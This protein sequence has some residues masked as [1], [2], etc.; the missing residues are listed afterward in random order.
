MNE[1]LGCLPSLLFLMGE[2]Q[3]QSSVK[4]YFFNCFSVYKSLYVLT[5]IT[6]KQ[7]SSEQKR[8]ASY[9]IYQSITGSKCISFTAFILYSYSIRFRVTARSKFYCRNGRN[10]F[11]GLIVFHVCSSSFAQTN[12]N[13][14]ILMRIG[15]NKNQFVSITASSNNGSCIMY[16]VKNE[17]MN[18]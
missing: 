6:R 18:G 16:M 11:S 9:W 4:S 8:F 2:I 3:I 1:R 14:N 17:W 15:K 13:N 12:N 10:R 5:I 7:P